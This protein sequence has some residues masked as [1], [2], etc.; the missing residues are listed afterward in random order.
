MSIDLAV[1]LVVYD[2]FTKPFKI[3]KQRGTFVTIEIKL[4]QSAHP[5]TPVE[6]TNM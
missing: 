2:V 1:L 5:F 4:A 3:T 6:L